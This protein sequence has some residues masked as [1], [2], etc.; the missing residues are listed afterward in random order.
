MKTRP[1]SFGRFL[2]LLVS[3][4]LHFQQEWGN[5]AVRAGGMAGAGDG[6]LVVTAESAAGRGVAGEK[7]WAVGDDAAG[8]TFPGLVM[9][10]YNRGG[11]A[12]RWVARLG[13][14]LLTLSEV[15]PLGDVA[16]VPAME[17]AAVWHLSLKSVGTAAVAVGWRVRIEEVLVADYDDK[18][19]GSYHA[20]ELERRAVAVEKAIQETHARRA[21]AKNAPMRSVWRADGTKEEESAEG[22]Y[23]QM[24][25]TQADMRGV[26]G[27]QP[28]TLEI[29]IDPLAVPEPS[30]GWLA[31]LSGL[32]VWV[33]RR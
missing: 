27:P 5:A 29:T 11:D 28:G 13:G 15:L 2:P 4:L 10:D 7:E 25:T 3:I 21:K 30:C 31:G 18:A 23:E 16:G 6:C 8:R 12:E 20:E 26:R 32:L 17:R 1:A 19:A 14:G 24:V 33:R 9:V 22:G